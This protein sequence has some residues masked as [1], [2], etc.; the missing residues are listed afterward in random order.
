MFYRGP[1]GRMRG[2]LAF[3]CGGVV[4]LVS[5]SAFAQPQQPQPSDQPVYTAPPATNQ[6]PPA[7]Q[8]PPVVVAPDDEK[9][10]GVRF[11]GGISG[12]GGAFFGNN[13]TAFLGGL[14]GRLGV[15]INHLFG[16][17][18]QP[19]LAFGSVTERSISGVTGVAAVTAVAELTLI[20]RIFI[21]AGAGGRVLNKP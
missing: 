15:Q 7:N 10:D 3:L 19:H 13:V 16:V 2:E 8:P 18:A 14:D 4:C 5:A 17:Y 11:R 6:P 12:G 21:G 20:D 1:G 9:K